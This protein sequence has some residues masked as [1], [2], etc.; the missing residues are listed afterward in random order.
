MIKHLMLAL[1]LMSA[2]SA[3]AAP[4]PERP[5]SC[6]LFDDEQRKC[7]FGSCDAPT[8]TVYARNACETEVGQFSSFAEFLQT[9]SRADPRRTY[10][11][12]IE[13]T[14]ARRIYT[15]LPRTR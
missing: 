6:R 5:Y 15:S 3:L 14:Q 11:P 4:Q 2:S 12:P 1:A 10:S 7:A 8:S 9:S 13:L